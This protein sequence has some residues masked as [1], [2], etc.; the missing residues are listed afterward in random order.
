MD[1]TQSDRRKGSRRRNPRDR[2]HPDAYFTAGQFSV[3]DRR[4]AAFIDDKPL[5][6]APKEYAL[7]KLLVINHNRVVSGREIVDT[8]WPAHSRATDSD[9][10]QYVY[11]LRN[12]IKAA[13]GN[14]QLIATVQGF[15]YQ[16]SD[17]VD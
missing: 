6:L 7:L 10:K 4:K 8:L 11:L 3:N 13:G 15:G 9:C 2:R 17:L 14:P 1:V 12:R 5:Q 16:I